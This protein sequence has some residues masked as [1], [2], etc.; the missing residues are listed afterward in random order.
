MHG[1]TNKSM[2]DNAWRGE[3]LE[4]DMKKYDEIEEFQFIPFREKMWE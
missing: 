2:N 3:V 4:D 1:G